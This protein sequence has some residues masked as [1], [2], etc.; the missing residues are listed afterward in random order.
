MRS[1]LPA[2]SAI[3]RFG[4]LSALALGASC[5]SSKSVVADKPGR[6]EV[7]FEGALPTPGP[8]GRIPISFDDSKPSKVVVGIQVLETDGKTVR[9]SFTGRDAW[10]RLSVSPG[11]VLAVDGADVAGPNVHLTNGEAHN[12]TV[13]IT[14]TYG[15]ARI[16]AQDVGYVPAAAGTIPQCSDGIDNDDNGYA[17]YP[18]DPN[19]FFIN[20]DS[21]KA[22]TQAYGVSKVVPFDFPRIHDVQGPGYTPFNGKQ[23]EIPGTGDVHM[24]VSHITKDGMFVVDTEQDL[25]A[26][27]PSHDPKFS[28][29]FIYNFNPP[30]EV[31][32]CDRITR[33]NG[34]VSIFGG[35]IQLGTAA[36]NKVPWLNP[37]ASGPCPLPDWFE[38]TDAISG[39]L[40]TMQGLQARLVKVK[41][42]VVGDHLGRKLA[43]KGIPDV[44]ASNCDLN[45]DGIAGCIANKPGYNVDE[46]KCCDLCNA[47]I[48]CTEW[49]DYQARGHVKMHFGGADG[50]LF[51]SFSQVNDFS[52]LDY[53]GKNK[54]AEIR[55]S[56]ATFTLPAPIPSFTVEARCADDVVMVDQDPKTIR[57]V[58]HACI[59][60][61]ADAD[62]D[63]NY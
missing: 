55:G 14:G 17:D 3:L 22:G 61:R 38:I 7:T 54:Y 23:V 32:V 52:P 20:D 5:S 40:G 6:I 15:D 16:V 10:V 56:I 39:Q 44:G 34:N 2:L 43:P 33:L 53:L 8:S 59:C 13:T 28:G 51:A 31:H 1:L 62:S 21:E 19:C 11:Q 4:A 30:A 12:L 42:P 57:D 37:T 24:Y 58:Q 29:I 48:E 41:N 18:V 9:T 45:G 35:A 63:C 46:T 47:D 27:D 36:W 49:N 60:T 25:S 50:V 26:I